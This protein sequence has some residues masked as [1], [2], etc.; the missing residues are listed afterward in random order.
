MSKMV[1]TINAGA[2][3]ASEIVRREVASWVGISL[4]P[5]PLT[6]SIEVRFRHRVLG[7]LHTPIGGV[8]TAD[9]I[10]SPEIGEALIAAGRAQPHPLIPALGW[11]SAGLGSPAETADVIALF[12]RNYERMGGD[13]HAV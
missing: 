9:L 6:G 10:F 7:H 2:T 8:A 11:V 5:G 1:G 13:L 12:R 3:S 4:G